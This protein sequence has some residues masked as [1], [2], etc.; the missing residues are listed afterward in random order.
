MSRGLAE[1]LKQLVLAGQ[2]GSMK[3][4][5]FPANDGLQRPSHAKDRQ[6]AGLP[7]HA[8]VWNIA[9][10]KQNMDNSIAQA[11]CAHETAKHNW[12]AA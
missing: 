2:C 12:H 1:T 8:G 5:G 11:C 7:E 6:T 9:A 3:H 4:R 10:T